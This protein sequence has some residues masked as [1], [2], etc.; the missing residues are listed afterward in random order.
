MLKKYPT[1]ITPKNKYRDVDMYQKRHLVQKVIEFDALKNDEGGKERTKQCCKAFLEDTNIELTPGYLRAHIESL[2]KRFKNNPRDNVFDT[3]GHLMPSIV[4]LVSIEK[5]SKKHDQPPPPRRR[6][7]DLEQ[8]IWFAKN[9]LRNLKRD[10]DN[11]QDDEHITS[12]HEVQHRV[13]MARLHSELEEL[14]HESAY[15]KQ[16]IDLLNLLHQERQKRINP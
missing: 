16:K 1:K 12:P 9:N 4:K 5:E 6:L 7:S 3:I 15:I 10:R 2:V 11:L 14:D 13:K 8:S